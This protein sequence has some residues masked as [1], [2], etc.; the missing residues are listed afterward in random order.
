MNWYH[1]YAP[2]YKWNPFGDVTV[3]MIILAGC[4]AIMFTWAWWDN[5][6]GRR[7]N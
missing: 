3:L 1:I 7:W 4:T 2:G 5:K 6:N